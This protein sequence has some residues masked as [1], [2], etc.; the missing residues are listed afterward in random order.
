MAELVDALAS[1]ASGLWAVEVQVFSQAPSF[2]Q[3][4]LPRWV[5]RIA[6]KAT[7]LRFAE[8][9]RFIS[10]LGEPSELCEASLRAQTN[11]ANLRLA[12]GGVLDSAL[13][14]GASDR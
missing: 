9:E 7:T 8:R 13:A 5:K 1:G 6:L 4:R 12:T 2:F 3:A 10:E 14:S 11:G